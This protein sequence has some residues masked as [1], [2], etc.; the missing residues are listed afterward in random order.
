[1][2]V[3]AALSAQALQPFLRLRTPIAGEQ[4]QPLVEHCQLLFFAAYD[5]EGY[6][7]WSP[8]AGDSGITGDTS[9]TR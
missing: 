5:R 4:L 8:R 1:V 6:V 2:A 9:Q 3:L 7:L